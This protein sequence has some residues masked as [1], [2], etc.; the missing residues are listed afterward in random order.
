MEDKNFTIGQKVKVAFS[1]DDHYDE[2][3]GM[4]GLVIQGP[5]KKYNWALTHDLFYAGTLSTNKH[6]CLI[7]AHRPNEEEIF[8]EFTIHK[9]F[10]YDRV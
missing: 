9:S 5:A 10:I 4:S 3:F 1:K 6:W 7:E 2:D 8:K